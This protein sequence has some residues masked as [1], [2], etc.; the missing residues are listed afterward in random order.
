MSVF[1]PHNPYTNYPAEYRDLLAVN[2]LSDTHA[3]DE[4]FGHRLIAHRLED[5]KKAG[6]I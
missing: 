3:L 5:R 1:D 4:P 2:A 6:P